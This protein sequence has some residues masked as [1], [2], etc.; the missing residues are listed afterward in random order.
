M[1]V[2]FVTLGTTIASKNSSNPAA[3]TDET[4]AGGD[5]SGLLASLTFVA[6]QTICD[7]AGAANEVSESAANS[8]DIDPY[9]Q[10]LDDSEPA[11]TMLLAFAASLP[12][13]ASEP[14]TAGGDETAAANS[15]TSPSQDSSNQ[16]AKND[17][18]NRQ[19]IRA[20]LLGPSFAPPSDSLV[21]IAK[22]EAGP[23][24]STNFE[25]QHEIATA[26]TAETPR[27]GG[28]GVA[29]PIEATPLESSDL[30]P[31]EESST[32]AI[33]T[34]AEAKPA[35]R[36][37]LIDVDLSRSPQGDTLDYLAPREHATA[38][39]EFKRIDPKQGVKFAA[40]LSPDS[41]ST[42]FE[43]QA[44]DDQ[45]RQA[46]EIFVPQ[47]PFARVLESS[48]AP[49]APDKAARLTNDMTDAP[50][51]P[52]APMAGD[53]KAA[54][55]I[56]ERSAVES[57]NREEFPAALQRV[58]DQI[59]HQARFGERQAVIELE[60]PELGKIRIDLR[61]EG[62]QIHARIVAEEQG[63]KALIESRLRE[64][65]QA[66]EVRQVDISN[67]RVEQQNVSSGGG[68]WG[69]SFSDGA[70][71]ERGQWKPSGNSA[72][73]SADDSR[74]ETATSYTHDPGRI[75]MWA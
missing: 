9:D 38:E 73:R 46:G 20:V 30:S 42:A 69:Q 55:S 56:Q 40:Q 37:G 11:T 47:S 59:V 67:L 7:G 24:G 50:P 65:R 53:A 43:L 64:L 52:L 51:H 72:D 13:V 23:C 22:E 45:D 6:P 12:A 32:R 33:V 28:V 44:I 74:Q 61:V 29:P 41:K 54:M 4:A 35:G 34:S 17:S 75:S 39:K 48:T 25:A 18:D 10:T 3:A 49:D 27:N 62:E 2:P 36:A 66:L 60:P 15:I 57:L 14:V 8:F 58:T 31:S 68:D 71:Q 21:A 63:T 16:G 70:R 19:A 1:S 5:F 26:P